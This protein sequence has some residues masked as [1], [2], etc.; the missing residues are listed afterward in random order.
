MFVDNT[1]TLRLSQ[2][3]EDIFQ[4]T[5]VR[6]MENPKQIENNIIDYI[7]KELK[8]SE[9]QNIMDNYQLK[10]IFSNA[11]SKEAKEETD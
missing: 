10:N 3:K 8:I 6:I 11:I 7:I 5:L 9:Y 2:S 1:T 4:S